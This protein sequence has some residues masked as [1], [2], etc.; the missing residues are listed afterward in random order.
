[1]TPPNRATLDDSRFFTANFRYLP[2]PK[3]H[4]ELDP[5]YPFSEVDEIAR[6]NRLLGREFMPW[7]YKALEVATQ[8][9]LDTFGRRVYKYHTIIVTV[10]R[11]SG[12]TTFTCPLMLHRM[13]TRGEPAAVF[14]TAQTG[15]DA[16]KRM[17]EFIELIESA[18]AKAVFKATRSNGGESIKLDG[19]PGCH[20]TKFSPTFSA[21]HGEHPHLVVLDEIWHFDKDLGEA[22][23]GAAEPA[24]VTLGRRAQVFMV[25]TMGTLKS[26]FMNDLIA[27]A[28]AGEDPGVCLIE[29]SMPESEDPFDP[30]T[31][32]KFHPALGNTI[33]EESLQ[34]RAI[35]A[36]D[37]PAKR[38]TWLRAYCNLLTATTESLFDLSIWDEHETPAL[39]PLSDTSQYVLSYEVA[40]AS[41]FAAVCLSWLDEDTGRPCTALLYQ[42]PGVAWLPQFVTDTAEKMNCPIVADGAGMSV[43][44]TET[45]HR[46]GM[47]VR[48]LS[49]TEYAQ[50][51]E[52]M[53]NLSQVEKTLMIPAGEGASEMREQAAAAAVSRSNGVRRF[54]RDKAARPT[55]AIIAAAVGLYALKHPEEE[56]PEVEPF[57]L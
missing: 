6:V 26:Q 10:P 18:P 14:F 51:T 34:D 13:M 56:K 54:S 52:E 11:Q 15:A 38:A 35:K 9:K 32:W 44:I 21:L 42:A 17:M 47:Q 36:Q 45:L 29:Y 33:T 23:L 24:Q 50:A 57:V 16:R 27:A 48:T 31:W 39:T 2:E 20:V 5:A 49:M 12:K 55:P 46:A 53:L 25:S 30:A 28:R 37:D 41:E 22:L 3:A 1:M 19:K 4:P 43:R 40:A 8:Y 7:Q